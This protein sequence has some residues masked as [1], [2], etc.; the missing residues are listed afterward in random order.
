M[1]PIEY[2]FTKPDGTKVYE[3]VCDRKDVHVFKKM[4]GAV[5]A[6]PVTNQ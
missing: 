5:S 1:K 6:K 3:I 2:E 4:H